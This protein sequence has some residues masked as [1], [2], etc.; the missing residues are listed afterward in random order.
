MATWEKQGRQCN[1]FV[2]MDTAPSMSYKHMI[3]YE[4]SCTWYWWPTYII[5]VYEFE[6]LQPKN[7]SNDVMSYNVVGQ[8]SIQ[9]S[10]TVYSQHVHHYVYVVCESTPGTSGVLAISEPGGRSFRSNYCSRAWPLTTHPMV[11]SLFKGW[12]TRQIYFG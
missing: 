2:Q 9:C 3:Y 5:Y 7:T 6:G 12:M 10:T 8:W 11:C 4:M 1:Q